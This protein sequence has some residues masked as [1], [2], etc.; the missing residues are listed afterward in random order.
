MELSDMKIEAQKL[1][2]SGQLKSRSN[3]KLIEWI[4]A[5][6]IEKPEECKDK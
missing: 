5:K 2:K 3:T 1:K 4:D 6:Y